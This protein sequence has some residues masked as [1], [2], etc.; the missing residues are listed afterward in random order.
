MR[1]HRSG[2]SRGAA[3]RPAARCAASKPGGAGAD[4]DIPSTLQ[5]SIGIERAIQLPAVLRGARPV[6]I[7]INFVGARGD[8]LF[9][10]RDI[11][12]PSPPLYAARPDATR[13]VVRQ[14]ES[15]GRM[16]EAS[17][18]FTLRGQVTKRFSG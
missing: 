6:T 12:A 4:A 16:R 7:A 11:N 9:R 18:H 15:A 3:A 10:S 14:I 17:L 8:H 13:N 2:L 5:Y 1:D